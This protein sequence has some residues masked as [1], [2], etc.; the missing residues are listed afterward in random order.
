MWMKE[1][2]HAE[3]HEDEK[4]EGR[5]SG[6]FHW[7]RDGHMYA[8]QMCW[9]YRPREYRKKAM[10]TFALCVQAEEGNRDRILG[11][12]FNKRLESFAPCYSQSLLLVDFK[13]NHSLMQVF[14]ILTKI[15]K[16]ENSSLF[17]N[18]SL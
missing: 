13:E 2:S 18:S 11:H 15:R 4:E 7:K 10:H 3:C 14:K 1:G 5:K 16:Q 12:Q 8:R 9:R 17:M 6:K